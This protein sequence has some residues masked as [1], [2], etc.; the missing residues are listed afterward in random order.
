MN[1][2]DE[3][4]KG[5][6]PLKIPKQAENFGKIKKV[7]QTRMIE[8]QNFHLKEDAFVLKGEMNFD[9]ISDTSLFLMSKRKVKVARVIDF[10]GYFVDDAR[11]LLNDLLSERLNRE[12][13]F[14][15]IIYGKG[16]RSSKFDRSPLKNAILG[17]LHEHQAISAFTQ[18]IDL[19]GGSGAVMVLVRK[20]VRSGSEK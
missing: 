2:C 4:K 9:G 17:L 20:R 16:N 11:I 8:A 1:D 14:W 15:E 18:I 7:K 10:H 12:E 3:W 19:D 13:E 5:V 6:K